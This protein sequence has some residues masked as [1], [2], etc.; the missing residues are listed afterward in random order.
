VESSQPEHVELALARTA[1][2]V[3]AVSARFGPEMVIVENLPYR[4]PEGAR[5]RLG[6]EPAFMRRL[7]AETGCG[8]LL[9]IAHA[10][11][12]A[13]YLGID[14]RAYLSSLPVDRV[15]ELHISGLHD[16]GAGAV[17]GEHM[18]LAEHDWE[19]LAWCLDEI[20]RGGHWARP[21]VLAFEYGGIGPR[22]EGRSDA[23]VLAEQL[24]RFQ[25]MV[26]SLDREIE[27]Q[28]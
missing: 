13:H 4:G 8:F 15:R 27:G 22:A 19:L 11:T 5:L 3:R 26:R 21:W 10:R 28:A 2:D 6:Q 1:K 12:A 18:P 25:A 16:D 7:C 23:A 20:R 9:D 24:P 17:R 14:E